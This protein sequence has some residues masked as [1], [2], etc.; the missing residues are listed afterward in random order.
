[1]SEKNFDFNEFIAG[2]I[3]SL[4]DPKGF[5]SGLGTT[6]GYLEPIIKALIFG[7]VA[8]IINYIWVLAGLSVAGFGFWGTAAGPMVI[9]GG[10]IGSVIALFIAAVIMLI[11]SA[12]CSGTTDYEANVRVT[13]SLM[14]LMPVNALVSF[15]SV[16]SIGL[17]TILGMFVSAYG[18]WMLYNALTQTLKATENSAKVLVI[19][20]LVLLVFFTIMGLIAGAFFKAAGY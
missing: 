20:L 3:K 5:F 13:A 15:V 9:V 19:V 11:F 16:I 1:M 10:L 2:A 14:V 17:A 4:K 12:I 8:A 7:G 6:G 18:L